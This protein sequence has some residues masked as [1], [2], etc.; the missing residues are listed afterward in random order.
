MAAAIENE[1]LRTASV[2]QSSSYR[3]RD[4]AKRIKYVIGCLADALGFDDHVAG[5]AVRLQELTD[6]I[7][8]AGR[9]NR[10]QTV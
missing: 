8:C 5:V 9:K 10:I 4:L 3:S 7:K 1:D 6:D 2:E